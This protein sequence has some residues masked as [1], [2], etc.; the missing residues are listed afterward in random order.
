MEQVSSYQ[1][2]AP[3]AIDCD[4]KGSDV[5]GEKLV[6]LCPADCLLQQ[7]TVFGTGVYASVSS[8]CG[9]A[10]HHGVITDEGGTVLLT[11]VSGRDNYHSTNANG[12]ISKHLSS[13]S[14]SFTVAIQAKA[15][16]ESNQPKAATASK[17]KKTK[18]A[19]K[20]P[21]LPHNKD[22]KVDIA[23]L[24][25]GSYNIGQRRFN[26][27]KNFLVKVTALL[28][29][30][31]EGPQVGFIQ[32]SEEPKIELYLNNFT[33]PKEIMFALREM[34]FRGGH[35]NIGKALKNTV[36]NFFSMNN[37]ARKGFPRIAVIFIDGWP[38]DDMEEA[39]VLARES[40]INVFVI[41]VSK[42]IAEEKGMVRDLAFAEKAA[43][44]NN[45]FFTYQIPSWFTTNK[46]VKP[47]VQKLCTPDQ[48]LCSKTC[49]NSVNI[50]FLI[51]GSSS[52]G[53]N[54]F[55][56]MLKFISSVG[57]AYEISDLGSKIGI[58][59]FTYDQK[60]EV[61]FT[62]YT[63]KD[64]AMSAIRNVP[65]MSG[66]T[67]T[68]DAINYAV[69]NLFGPVMQ[70]PNKN[71]LVVITDGQ[72]YDDVRDPAAAAQKAGITMYAFGV[73]WA[74]Q[75]DLKAM[76]S[77]PKN[78]HNFFTREFNGLEQLVPDLVQGICKDFMEAQ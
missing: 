70:G 37:G 60:M 15:L 72:S 3:T 11:K 59:Q 52:V 75:E 16:E 77:E 65:Y 68:G 39:A 69:K 58:V 36:Q 6:A 55:R 73:A 18:T 1:P 34:N 56:L 31:S 50:G 48:L 44:K 32:A 23:F 5:L 21:V 38:S 28:R 47:L 27:Q 41:T 45:S 71:F 22:C 64:E 53:D 62:D 10:I 49:Y 13:W 40:G 24:L 74:P 25:D 14:S 61:D 4:T 67:A 76:A 78:S 8:I 30:G 66:G 54:N 7:L 29:V 42:P 57:R 43:C 35:S 51:D 26:L 63:T 12:I 20:K 19:G 33:Q 9:A 2:I 17:A 46:F